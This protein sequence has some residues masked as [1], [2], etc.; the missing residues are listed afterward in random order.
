[1]RSF[2][3]T[4]MNH[5]V[6]NSSPPKSAFKMGNAILRPGR[7]QIT[8]CSMGLKLQTPTRDQ[9][10]VFR[11][12]QQLKYGYVILQLKLQQGPAPPRRAGLQGDQGRGRFCRFASPALALLDGVTMK[13][14]L[15]LSLLLAIF[16]CSKQPPTSTV[17]EPAANPSATSPGHPANNAAPTRGPSTAASGT[18]PTTPTSGMAI[19]IEQFDPPAPGPISR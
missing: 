3:R 8:R 6:G 5:S 19:F 17:P 16:A 7:G 4:N 1:V 9:E 11:S 13:R 14:L 15:M 10:P 2:R 12:L 18:M